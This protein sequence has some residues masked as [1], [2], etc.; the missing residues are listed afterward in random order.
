MKNITKNMFLLGSALTVCVH[1]TRGSDYN[2]D[3][4][5]QVGSK[6]REAYSK[7]VSDFLEEG[8][9]PKDKRLPELMCCK[10]VDRMTELVK[11]YKKSRKETDI[12]ILEKN[13]EPVLEENKDYLSGKCCNFAYSPIGFGWS[14]SPKIAQAL[15]ILDVCD[16]FKE[17][18]ECE[19]HA[20]HARMLEPGLYVEE[21]VSLDVL[22]KLIRGYKRVNKKAA[23]WESCNYCRPSWDELE[24]SWDELEKSRDELEKSGDELEERGH[25]WKKWNQSVGD[26]LKSQEKNKSEKEIFDAFVGY[27]D[28]PLVWCWGRPRLFSG[29]WWAETKLVDKD[30]SRVNTDNVKLCYNRPAWKYYHSAH[31]R[32]WPTEDCNKDFKLVAKKMVK[33]CKEPLTLLY[34]DL[35]LERKDLNPTLTWFLDKVLKPR[36]KKEKKA[37]LPKKTQEGTPSEF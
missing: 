15:E 22:C 33:R 36:I 7:Q 35:S 23:M 5:E 21:Q 14:P 6:I 29:D 32:C 2:P 20:M 26:F 18:Y 31:A 17:Q 19:M 27:N 16:R 3:Y 13:F 1:Y 10:C 25:V 9:A 12:S 8:Y 11:K 28:N 37:K 30:D 34:R 24:K 4:R